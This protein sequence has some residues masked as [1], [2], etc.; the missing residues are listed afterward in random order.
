MTVLSQMEMNSAD[1]IPRGVELTNDGLD[2][3]LRACD[4]VPE[5]AVERRPEVLQDSDAKVFA[6]RHR[7]HGQ[8]QRFKLAPRRRRNQCGAAELLEVRQSAGAT[9]VK[10]SKL[11]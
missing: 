11:T 6:T 10:R 1:Q 3:P 4:A 7:G 5:C 2:R 9:H 8:D